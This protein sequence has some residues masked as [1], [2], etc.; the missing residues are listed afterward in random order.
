MSVDTQMEALTV[1]DHELKVNAQ[2]YTEQEHSFLNAVVAGVEG[3]SG[4]RAPVQE[5]WF[6]ARHEVQ[7][8]DESF[9]NGSFGQ[10]YRGTYRNADVVVQ[11]LE[12]ASKSYRQEFLRQVSDLHDA[13]HPNIVQFY[14]ACHVGNPCCMVY[15]HIAGGSLPEY[16]RRFRSEEYVRRTKAWQAVLGVVRGLQFLHRRG[17]VHGN[18]TG[19]SIVIE[20]D[21]AM[22]SGFGVSCVGS[23]SQPEVAS[24]GA[25]RWRAPELTE[26]GGV[27]FEADVYSLGMCIVEAVTGRPPW[28]T[29]TDR[30]VRQHLDQG[31]F[32]KQPAVV[33]KEEW[34]LI[35]GMCA[36]DP[37]VR[38]SLQQVETHLQKFAAATNVIPATE[39]E[40]NMFHDAEDIVATWLD[41]DVMIR[42]YV[43]NETGV[44]SF[45]VL[46][47]R[48]I[49]LR[50]PNIQKLF[51]GVFEGYNFFVCEQ[52]PNGS[53]DELMEGLSFKTDG[54]YVVAVLGHFY[55]AALG[56]QYL[57]DRGIAYGDF[58]LRNMLVSGD[59]HAKLPQFRRHQMRTAL[60]SFKAKRKGQWLQTYT[61][62]GD[63][64]K[65]SRSKWSAAA[66]SS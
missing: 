30:S 40:F 21:T 8:D 29:M 53:M 35:C 39:I 50:H 52:M 1:L 44:E 10:T 17:I 48:G 45:D 46:I 51:G 59:G 65:D 41:A 14:G 61:R 7:V 38:P 34:S 47:S 56:L 15:K 22:I 11:C 16:L 4:I 25:M 63:A 5:R 55:E 6:I 27:S 20:G 19:S 2:N 42:P 37:S 13:R 32:M 33:S 24:T 36:F 43:T 9:S 58:S 62:L 57:H 31:K 49:A 23:G 64:S 18:L 54:S 3:V 28:G 26:S 12:I 60:P 66:P